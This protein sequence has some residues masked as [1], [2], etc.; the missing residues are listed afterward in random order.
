MDTELP[1]AFRLPIALALIT[2]SIIGFMLGSQHRDSVP[3][4]SG[5]LTLM[6]QQQLQHCTL[7]F[8]EYVPSS[9]EREWA[10]VAARVGPGDGVCRIMLE[11]D[12]PWTS[13]LQTWISIG[14]EMDSHRVQPRQLDLFE[15]QTQRMDAA[16]DVLSRMVYTDTCTGTLVT[17]FIAPL[18]GLLRDPRPICPI[19]SPSLM[20]LTP[21]SKDV[22]LKSS[23][24][25]DPRFLAGMRARLAPPADGVRSSHRAFLFDAGSTTWLDFMGM[26]SVHWLVE[27]FAAFGIEF[28]QIFAW[29]ATPHP[30]F[31]F[32]EGMPVSLMG[33]VTFFNFA[34]SAESQNATNPLLVIKQVVRPGDFVVFKLDIDT[35]AV[36]SALVQQLLTD[37]EL[38]SVVDVLL[39]EDHY[40]IE[41]MRKWW[42]NSTA[43]N[44]SESIRMFTRLRSSGI[45]AQVWP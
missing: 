34:V 44:L 37:T 31:K 35:P 18:A 12:S 26:S 38:H 6:Q 32:Y 29:E 13:R 1:T 15:E 9:L 22:Q 42:R 11:K 28:D 21:S 16:S 41:D 2:V 4:L 20:N 36:E 27:R 3:F 8:V 17:S 14:E 33:R 30:G 25:F 23:I 24:I 5:S 40:T 43:R 39:Y 45:A 7:K 10:T 19:Q